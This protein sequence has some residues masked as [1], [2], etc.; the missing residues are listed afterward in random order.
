[1]PTKTASIP[2]P[3][4]DIKANLNEYLRERDQTARYT[5]SDYCF[6]YFQAYRDADTISQISSPNNLELSCV[7]LG[8]YLAS[9]GMLRA[10]STLLQKSMKHYV[11]VI[12][13]I[14]ST[15]PELWKIDSHD[16]TDSNIASL[17]QI[18]E[19]LRSSLHDGA[20]DILITKIMLGVFGC[21]P[22]FDNY[23]C[24][25]FRTWSMSSKALRR[26]GS[27]Y[28]ENSEI[29]DNYRV[30]TIDFSTGKPTKRKYTRAKVIDMIFWIKGLSEAK[31]KASLNTSRAKSP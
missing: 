15:R 18:A 3:L 10:S 5:S 2:C 21:V 7:Q 28:K 9:W 23:F 4:V 12:R 25:G 8:F 29:I 19:R 31:R 30:P 6:N 13:T 24:S 17:T 20:S 11:P 26:I 27:Y 22:A 16:Y 1:M 14:A